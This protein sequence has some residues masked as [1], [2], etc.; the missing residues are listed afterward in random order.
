MSGRSIELGRNVA[1]RAVGDKVFRRA[2]DL[3]VRAGCYAE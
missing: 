3:P 1:E 2:R